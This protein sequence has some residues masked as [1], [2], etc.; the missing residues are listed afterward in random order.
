MVDDGRADEVNRQALAP[1]GSLGREGARGRR[2][3]GAQEEQAHGWGS[4]LAGAA[5]R[6]KDGSCWRVQG[7][8]YKTLG[9]TLAVR[10]G[11][12]RQAH[13]LAQSC[14]RLHLGEQTLGGLAC[15]GSL[16]P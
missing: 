16:L 7:W 6:G 4:H 2:G 12:G 9:E 3:I 13:I 14:T 8:S 11:L 5:V 1:G 15:Q 10:I